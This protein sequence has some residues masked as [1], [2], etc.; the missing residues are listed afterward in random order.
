MIYRWLYE[1]IF[2]HLIVSRNESGPNSAL[3]SVM[4]MLSLSFQSWK[5]FQ[6]SVAIVRTRYLIGYTKLNNFLS[7]INKT[8]M[9]IFL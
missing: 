4:E 9:I 7:C 6:K 1:N 2:C 5:T 3:V 8:T